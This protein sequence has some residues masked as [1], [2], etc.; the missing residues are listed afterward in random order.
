MEI[1]TPYRSL[2][3]RNP[4][5]GNYYISSAGKLRMASWEQQGEVRK[6]TLCDVFTAVLQWENKEKEKQWYEDFSTGMAKSYERL[7]HKID[8][9][10]AITVGIESSHI[11]CRDHCLR[12][13][14]NYGGYL[15]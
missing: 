8:G 5:V 1:L 15:F 10:L 2:E 14:S 12:D 13:E 3:V 4:A 7:G 9:L 11:K 6:D